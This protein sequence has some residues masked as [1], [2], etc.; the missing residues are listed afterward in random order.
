MSRVFFA[1]FC[2]ILPYFFLTFSVGPVIIAVYDEKSEREIDEKIF[3]R[4]SIRAIKQKLQ[5]ARKREIVLEG[6]TYALSTFD[7]EVFQR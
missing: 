7:E 1:F 2:P 3:Q 4:S 5:I 6:F